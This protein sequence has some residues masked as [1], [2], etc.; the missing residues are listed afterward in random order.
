MRGYGF[1]DQSS[2]PYGRDWATPGTGQIR[3]KTLD[4]GSQR[5][6]L[7][8]L[9]MLTQKNV[10]GP[11]VRK[12]ALQ[13]I[14]VCGSREDT[15]ELEAIFQAVKHGMPHVPP[16]RDGYKYVADPNWSDLFTAPE[17]ILELL[18]EGANGGDCDDHTALICAL[19]GS[20]GFK[21]GLR[22]YGRLALNG[23]FEHVYAVVKTPKRSPHS[24]ELALDTT[25]HESYVG[26]EPPPGNVMT[27]WLE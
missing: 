3:G 1:G 20:I 14:N 10:V 13:I 24:G 23:D 2:A 9:A 25:V 6:A 15:C 16:L 8:R 18:L 12:T 19:A 27:A 7:L 26:W 4:A 21:V 17:R 5:N 22:A 11:L